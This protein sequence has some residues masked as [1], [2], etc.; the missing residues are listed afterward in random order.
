MKIYLK[1]FSGFLY[2]LW[3]RLLHIVGN[4][5]VYRFPMFVV[6][7]D[8]TLGMDGR[9]IDEALDIHVQSVHPIDF[10]ECDR[11]CIMRPKDGNLVRR[12]V[13][14]AEEHE[15]RSVPYDFDFNTDDPE[16]VYCFELCARCYPS[17]EFRK[18]DQRFFLGLVRKTT[19]LSESFIES[20]DFERVFEWNPRKR[21]RFSQ[22]AVTGESGNRD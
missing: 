12:A 6:Y 16:D 5:K 13:E 2:H 15:R 3:A 20:R 19:Y 11:I 21:V 17:L 14:I 10:M 8:S 7:D 9:M 4:V 18:Y 22:S 1:K